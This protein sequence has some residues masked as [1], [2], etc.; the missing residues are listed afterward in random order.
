MSLTL[1]RRDGSWLMAPSIYRWLT[2]TS[3]LD[4]CLIVLK[5]MVKKQGFSSTAEVVNGGRKTMFVIS[6]GAFQ[7]DKINIFFAKICIPERNAYIRY[8]WQVNRFRSSPLLLIQRNRPISVVNWETNDLTF[9][10]IQSNWNV[11]C[12]HTLSM[13]MS[14][15]FFPLIKKS[16]KRSSF[17]RWCLFPANTFSFSSL[18]LWY[19]IRYVHVENIASQQLH[20]SGKVPTRWWWMALVY[21]LLSFF[22][23]HQ[24]L[25]KPCWRI[26]NRIGIVLLTWEKGDEKDSS[27]AYLSKKNYRWIGSDSRR[28][29]IGCW[30]ILKRSNRTEMNSWFSRKRESSHGL[31]FVLPLIAIDNLLLINIML[32][33]FL[34]NRTTDISFLLDERNHLFN[35]PPSSNNLRDTVRDIDG[36]DYKIVVFYISSSSASILSVI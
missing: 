9:S 6:V 13:I 3:N 27:N 11:F 31:F 26:R 8:S 20:W 1:R 28:R 17:S 14:T 25:I 10:V 36:K 19:L 16:E 35:I 30:F 4:L 34:E 23:N 5:T 18:V 22:N 24:P 33:R 15:R 21:F 2:V 12:M 29:S 7:I 32:S